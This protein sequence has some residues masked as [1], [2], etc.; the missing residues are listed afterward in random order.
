VRFIAAE[1]S[2][3]AFHL[4]ILIAGLLMIAGGIVSGAGIVNPGRRFEAVPAGGAAAAGECGHGADCDC[5]EGA[6]LVAVGDAQA[7]GAA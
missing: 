6:P 1:A 4:G 5:G 7:P 3:D 2:A